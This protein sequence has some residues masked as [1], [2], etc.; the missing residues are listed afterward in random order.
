MHTKAARAFFA[1]VL[2]LG[3]AGCTA[4]PGAATEPSQ[5][6]D[7]AGLDGTYSITWTADE[8]Y[9]RF[10]GTENPEARDIAEGNDGELRLT[11]SDG[12]YELYYGSDG[13]SCPGTYE[14]ADD[15]VV[16][17]A[18]I[19]PSEWDCGDGVGQMTAD[20]EWLVDGEGLILTDWELSPEPAI[21]WAMKALVGEVLLER[22]H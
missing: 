7:A 16:M 12:E 10:G 14:V 6:G 11:F 18:T 2:L 19:D 20:A 22:T 1:A 8:L 3:C 13:S 4:D 15:R 9:E 21:D 17:T 5:G